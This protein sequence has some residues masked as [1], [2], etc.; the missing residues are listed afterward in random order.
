MWHTFHAARH[1]NA[2]LLQMC[3][4]KREDECQSK[5]ESDILLHYPFGALTTQWHVTSSTFFGN[6]FP[7]LQSRYLRLMFIVELSASFS[8]GRMLNGVWMW[9]MV[10]LFWGLAVLVSVKSFGCGMK[11]WPL[12]SEELLRT[13]ID[14]LLNS[15][16]F[17]HHLLYNAQRQT[18]PFFK[19]SHK[20]SDHEIISF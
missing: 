4:N 17:R 9:W 5:Y 8:A 18:E 3:K 16:S 12:R 7:S 13:F 14:T 6:A 19:S 10:W 15:S 1:F 2:P 11:V 20:S